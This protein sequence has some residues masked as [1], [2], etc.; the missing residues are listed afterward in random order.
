[1]VA[2]DLGCAYSF[3][4]AKRNRKWLV[5]GAALLALLAFAPDRQANLAI[6][7]QRAGDPSPQKVEAAV[8]LGLIAVSVLVTWSRRLGY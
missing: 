1:M 4:M 2:A 3:T 7:M 8:D 6:S 5:L